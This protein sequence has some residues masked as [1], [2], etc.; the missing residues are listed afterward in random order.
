VCPAA[1]PDEPT[2]EEEEP[3][4]SNPNCTTGNA[5]ACNRANGFFDFVSCTCAFPPIAAPE[6][7]TPPKEYTD[8]Y[9]DFSDDDDW[10]LEEEEY[11]LELTEAFDD[12]TKLAIMNVILA[13]VFDLLVSKDLEK[14][15][16]AASGDDDTGHAMQRVA[17]NEITTFWWGHLFWSQL[18]KRLGFVTFFR[19]I[20]KYSYI[21]GFFV[22]WIMVMPFFFKGGSL[23]V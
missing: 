19:V 10:E 14:D 21:P 15:N 3:L 11:F 23:G 13:T 22:T 20:V 9:D 8:D 7:W 1:V 18:Y 5:N 6:D 16:R 12:Y 4:A 2:V 17:A